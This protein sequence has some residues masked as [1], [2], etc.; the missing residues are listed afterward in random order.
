MFDE[1]GNP[2][3]SGGPGSGY[4]DSYNVDFSTG[5]VT[6]DGSG[7]SFDLGTLP[8][9]A[10]IIGG[11]RV[12]LPSTGV[13]LPRGGIAGTLRTVA[14]RIPWARLWP[15]VR[16]LGPAGVATALGITT[17]LLAQGLMSKGMK[18]KRR[19]GISSRDVRTTTRV[20]RFVNR[21]Q[22]QIGCVHS[23]RAHFARRRSHAR[24]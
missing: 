13:A 18:R 5:D 14:G 3:D 7:G 15:A 10:G 23:P 8:D 22:Q 16:T 24:A 6:S 4:D 1:F 20:V 9:L 2:I 21:M 12:G 19:R 11:T 17:E